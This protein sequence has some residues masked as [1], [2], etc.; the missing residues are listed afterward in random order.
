[1]VVIEESGH[2]FSDST[3]LVRLET[4]DVKDQCVHE[5]VVPFPQNRFY[6]EKEGKPGGTNRRG[7]KGEVALAGFIPRSPRKYS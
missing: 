1:M 4:V 2:S 3:R 6:S 5:I 7:N